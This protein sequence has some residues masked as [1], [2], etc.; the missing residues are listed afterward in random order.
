[1]D[2]RFPVGDDQAL[3]GWTYGDTT[4][5]T[6]GSVTISGADITLTAIVETGFWITFESN[7]GSY[8]PPQF[9]SGT[10]VE[11]AAPTRFGYSFAGWYTDSAFASAADFGAIKSAATLYAKWDLAD[12]KYTVIYWQ[13]NA[14]DDNYSYKESEVLTG[15]TGTQTAAVAK[16]YNGFT[17]QTFEQAVIAADGS[18]II[19]IYYKRNVFS[20]YF[21]DTVWDSSLEKRVQGSEFVNLRIT[22]KHGATIRDQWPD[23]DC[24]W[25]TEIDSWHFQA[26][27]DVMPLGDTC[28]FRAAALGHE[29]AGYYLEDLDGNYVLDHTDTGAPDPSAIAKEDCYPIRGFTFKEY[30]A[31]TFVSV[32][33]NCI[34]DNYCGAKF[35]YTRNSYKIDYM[36]NADTPIKTV[37][38]KYEA[39]ISD[40]ADFVPS[41]PDGIPETYVFEGW[42]FDE[43][44]KAKCDFT[45]MTMPYNNIV[46]YAN[47]VAPTFTVTVY[48]KDGST[49]L[50]TFTEVPLNA[51]IDE[52]EMPSPT[53]ANNES[54]LGWSLEDGSLFSFSTKITRDYKLYAIVGNSDKL[55]ITY[56]ANDG[57]S[58]VRQDPKSYAKGAEA[59]VLDNPFTPPAGKVFLGWNTAA[60]GSG[61]LYYPNSSIE[62][63]SNITL[64]AVWGDQAKAVSVTYHANDGTSASTTINALA[65]NSLIEIQSYDSLGLPMRPGYSFLGW[66]TA[67]NGSVEYKPG[68][69]ARVDSN[70][71]NDLYAQWEFI[72]YKLV[73]TGQSATKTYTGKWQELTDFTVEGLPEGFTLSG[74][75]YRARG[76]K[77]GSYD[78]RFSGTAVVKDKEGN[79]LTSHCTIEYVPGILKITSSPKTGDSSDLGLWLT[80]LT[81]SAMGGSAVLFL[82]RKR[83]SD[84]K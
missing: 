54:L 80:L 18:T 72:Q 26:N 48:D 8:I 37:D 32:N 49:V 4:L 11:P 52:T 55:T 17:A 13:E 30:V 50:K 6:D 5:P 9:V 82:G 42:Y 71:S 64:Y 78:G 59:I 12:S 57:T 38:Y 16:D 25:E 75:T 14:D 27:I 36:N 34:Y 33:D 84:E 68:D 46:V 1:M 62:V 67:P 20:V 81:V 43:G 65:N 74:I 19:N 24:S 79:D 3:T 40:A 60:D 76:L 7:G 70:G 69:H 23:M 2:V 22:A 61:T 31:S 51:V 29:S 83:R 44:C 28:F 39:D 58:A 45:G 15:A 73:V 77:V 53:L 66:S 10:A 56:A 47:W 35:Y 21:Y 41:R 63:P